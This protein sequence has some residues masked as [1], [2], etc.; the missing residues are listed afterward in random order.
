MGGVLA[1]ILTNAPQIQS[2]VRKLILINSPQGGTQLADKIFEES[3][4]LPLTIA[5]D[6]AFDLIGTTPGDLL[7]T[8]PNVKGMFKPEM[9][10]L[11]LNYYTQGNLHRGAVADLRTRLVDEEGDPTEIAHIVTGVWNV[12]THHVVTRT[13]GPDDN[14]LG[15]SLEVSGM[16]SALG[17]LCN[18]TPTR[19]T[20]DATQLLKTSV[21]IVKVM[22]A[23]T[24]ALGASQSRMGVWS[25]SERQKMMVDLIESG[26]KQGFQEL[27]GLTAPQPV[28][29]GPN[30]RVVP[31]WSQ[32]GNGLGLPSGPLTFGHDA[33][34]QVT[35]T[36]DHQSAKITPRLSRPM[37]KHID[38]KSG[39]VS[40]YE[41]ITDM[42]G[43]GKPDPTCRVMSLLED[44][45]GSKRFIKTG[46]Q[47]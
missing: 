26:V 1:R 39:L 38:P 13:T 22:F 4:K 10:S 42:N 44:D 25:Y 30:D 5:P 46:G 29:D 32:L 21:N 11:V 35:G 12:P 7:R 37:C 6:E 8:R 45:P 9:C 24:K 27:L 14:V 28:F 41:D 19:D 34:T 33:V 40:F 17:L 23:W 3:R 18:L 20:A 31:E 43:D 15:N 16:W 2:A 47:H 36:T